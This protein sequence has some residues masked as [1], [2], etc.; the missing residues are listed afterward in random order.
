MWLNTPLVQSLQ[1]APPYRVRRTPPIRRSRGA[2]VRTAATATLLYACS[3]TSDMLNDAWKYA[4]VTQSDLVVDLD[5]D[6]ARSRDPRACRGLRRVAVEQ[7]GRIVDIRHGDGAWPACSRRVGE[8]SCGLHRCLEADEVCSWTAGA[9][10]K[11]R[12][13]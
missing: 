2:S 6:A 10:S 13:L 4:R 9:V 8:S 11:H 7:R 3:S 1:T 12:W 5:L